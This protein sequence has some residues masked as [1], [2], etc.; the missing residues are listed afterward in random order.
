M[1]RMQLSLL[2]V[3]A[4]MAASI[5]A[6]TNHSSHTT[7]SG[8]A[9][10]PAAS[11]APT[12]TPKPVNRTI[13]EAG[14]YFYGKLDR[15]I[16]TAKNK[17]GDHFTL[18]EASSRPYSLAGSEIDGHLTDVQPAR[19]GQPATMNLVFD[20]IRAF[21]GTTAPVDA[22]LLTQLTPKSPNADIELPA[23]T[24]IELRFKSAA[25]SSASQ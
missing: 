12:P 19:P 25:R 11:G 7:S 16:G 4:C 24:V 5:T 22:E 1:N 20:D 18:V 6:C 23:R 21:D 14:T 17:D 3:A 8:S 2:I 9:A 10:T 15:A 13:A